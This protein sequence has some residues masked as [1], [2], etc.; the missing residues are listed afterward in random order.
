MLSDPACSHADLL[1][2]LASRL[3]AIGGPAA[4][5]AIETLN[6]STLAHIETVEATIALVL[7]LE[8]TPPVH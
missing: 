8:A 5:L 6:D 1:R 7:A 4:L 3:E 2:Q